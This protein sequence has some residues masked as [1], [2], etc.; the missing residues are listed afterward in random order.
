ML[1]SAL[2]AEPDSRLLQLHGFGGLAEAFPLVERAAL[3][4]G[5]FLM[6]NHGKLSV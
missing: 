6:G 2:A 1:L 4:R 5:P 3:M